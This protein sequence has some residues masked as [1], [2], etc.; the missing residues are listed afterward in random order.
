MSNQKALNIETN[1][2][3][4]YSMAA[5]AQCAVTQIFLKQLYSTPKT[6]LLFSI[7]SG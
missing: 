6:I 5:R 3:T 2:E 7:N 1:G 4:L